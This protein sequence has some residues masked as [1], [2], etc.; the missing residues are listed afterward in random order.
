MA[1]EMTGRPSG[2]TDICPIR[3]A[4]LETVI[5]VKSAGPDREWDTWDDI[6]TW[7]EEID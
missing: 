6:T 4:A 2:K 5:G 1:E 3:S 7:P